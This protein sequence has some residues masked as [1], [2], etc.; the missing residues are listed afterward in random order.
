MDGET[1]RCI[2]S[3]HNKEGSLP[4]VTT[5]IDLE[6]IVLN[7]VSQRDKDNDLPYMWDLETELQETESR[8]MIL[9]RWGGGGG[10][11]GDVG[12]KNKLPVKRRVSS[13]GLM[14]TTGIIVDDTVFYTLKLLRE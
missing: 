13:G 12:Q 6:G 10:Y 14:H 4:L 11:W 9:R 8:M 2:L 1:C 3:N 5:W 7:K